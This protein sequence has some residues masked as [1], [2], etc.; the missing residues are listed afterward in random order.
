MT[1][2]L[3]GHWCS[4]LADA[5]ERA[6]IACVCSGLDPMHACLHFTSLLLLLDSDDCA[7]HDTSVSQSLL[8][9]SH[10][11]CA[12]SKLRQTVLSMRCHFFCFP[13]CVP[14]ELRLACATV[15]ATSSHKA[16]PA[17]PEFSAMRSQPKHAPPDNCVHGA[18]SR[19]ILESCIWLTKEE[20]KERL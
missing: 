3:T 2:W 15:T 12:C 5:N 13:S 16:R 8:R 10:I 17:L 19:G 18:Q 20:T 14:P 7:C 11:C 6:V 4:C 9:R 1:W